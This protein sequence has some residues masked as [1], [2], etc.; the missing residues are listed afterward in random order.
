LFFV[1]LKIPSKE[2][3]KRKVKNR[4]SFFL[5]NR[6]KNVGIPLGIRRRKEFF[7][8]FPFLFEGGRRTKDF[9]KNE[10]ENSIV[11][12]KIMEGYSYE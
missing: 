11:S 12:R 3:E 9:Q 4:K 1:L 7:L 2:R 10:K 8:S 6:I 5:L